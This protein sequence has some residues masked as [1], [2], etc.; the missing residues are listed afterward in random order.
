MKEILSS[1][2]A[3]IEIQRGRALKRGGEL[4]REVYVAS[5][6]SAV[7]AHLPFPYGD[8]TSP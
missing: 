4:D 3:D 6:S 5:P 1:W 2:W 7:G 8:L